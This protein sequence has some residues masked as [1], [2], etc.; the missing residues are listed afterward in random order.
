VNVAR[1]G[2]RNEKLHPEDLKL[3]TSLQGFQPA[4]LAGLR[5]QPAEKTQ[6]FVWRELI[7]S[8]M[9]IRFNRGKR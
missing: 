3:I 2:N 8:E 1:V 7:S 4:E 6:I 9:G 5:S